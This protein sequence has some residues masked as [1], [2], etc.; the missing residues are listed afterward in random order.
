MKVHI[1]AENEFISFKE[2]TRHPFDQ[3]E[4]TMK[5]RE[6]KQSAATP[7]YLYLLTW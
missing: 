2:K 6:R 5:L 7:T 4:G 1:T 3:K